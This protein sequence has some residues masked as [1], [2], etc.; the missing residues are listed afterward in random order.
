M[1]I[2]HM[3]TKFPPAGDLKQPWVSGT[4]SRCP[5][6]FQNAR[7]P[8][9]VLELVPDACPD[10]SKDSILEASKINKQFITWRLQFSDNQLKHVALEFPL[11]T[12]TALNISLTERYPIHGNR[13]PPEISDMR[14]LH[15]FV[16]LPDNRNAGSCRGLFASKLQICVN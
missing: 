9:A 15:Y 3:R 12:V 2:W 10:R 5:R 8:P 13:N 7:Q 4:S 14:R 16:T 1:S 11:A 6:L